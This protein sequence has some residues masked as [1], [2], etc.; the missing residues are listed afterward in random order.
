MPY[1]LRRSL[2]ANYLFL[3]SRCVFGNVESPDEICL[4]IESVKP[5]TKHRQSSNAPVPADGAGGS[6]I[7]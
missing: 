6:F 5:D 4:A 3:L 7:P 1:S 2:S